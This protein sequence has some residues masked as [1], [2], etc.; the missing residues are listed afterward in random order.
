M[1]SDVEAKGG[2]RPATNGS[3]NENVIS[4][5]LLELEK[6]LACKVRVHRSSPLRLTAEGLE[7]TKISREFFEKLDDFFRRCRNL[8]STVTIGAGDSVAHWLLLPV[9]AN[10]QNEFLTQRLNVSVVAGSTEKLALMLREAQIDLALLGEI[11]RKEKDWDAAS[12]GNYSYCVVCHED[13]LPRQEEFSDVIP[14]TIPFAIVREHWGWNFPKMIFDA[15]AGPNG[16]ILLET[17]THVATLVRTEK[18]AGIL[19]VSTVSSFSYPKFRSFVPKFLN[20]TQQELHMVW[21]SDVDEVKMHDLSAKLRIET[22][23]QNLLIN[24]RAEL[25]KREQIL[26]KRTKDL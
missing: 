25:L 7:L 8:S 18:F 15:G 16:T 4:T 5:A 13:L 6:A 23:R 17:F 24:L 20:S 1:L 12:V 14:D 9:L 26:K 2:I 3:V 21:K 10:L 22:F 19:P 11:G